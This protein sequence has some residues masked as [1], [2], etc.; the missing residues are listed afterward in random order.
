[1]GKE[2]D[3]L[4]MLREAKSSGA[5]RPSLS[6]HGLLYPGGAI[7]EVTVTGIIPGLNDEW[8]STWQPGT[9]QILAQRGIKHAN[10]L[11][12]TQGRDAALEYIN[13]LPDD[14]ANYIYERSLGPNA[15][16]ANDVV[17][18]KDFQWLNN[19][20][21]GATGG[22]PGVVISGINAAKNAAIKNMSN[23]KYHT[24]GQA[25][26]GGLGLDYNNMPWYGKVGVEL[27][28]SPEMWLR[29]STVKSG[30]KS[31][32][33][34]IQVVAQNTK[35]LVGR[36]MTNSDV[37]P[38]YS[39][40]GT[41]SMNIPVVKFKKI[42]K[43]PISKV[44]ATVQPSDGGIA[45]N[46]FSNGTQIGTRVNYP[47]KSDGWFSRNKIE[48]SV[49]R[50]MGEGATSVEY[51]YSYPKEGG[52][53]KEF[54]IGGKKYAKTYDKK[55]DLIKTE[56]IS[57]DTRTALTGDAVPK[58]VFEVPSK[59][60]SNTTTHTVHGDGSFW[61]GLASGVKSQTP[62][63]NGV[64]GNAFGNWLGK[65]GMRSLYG[66][67]AYELGTFVSTLFTEHGLPI[68][69]ELFLKRLGENPKITTINDKINS[70]EENT[71]GW[72]LFHGDGNLLERLKTMKTDSEEKAKEVLNVG[73][74]NPQGANITYSIPS[75]TTN[76]S[77]ITW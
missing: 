10:N 57:G 76:M 47:L 23:G 61:G 62:G 67:G 32:G 15:D 20:M 66:L 49:D 3:K 73:N 34:G 2:K 25:I 33:N 19:F 8:G 42:G 39:T 77:K 70:V 5:Q 43:M 14:Y 29:P 50:P 54:E 53:V 26:S 18:R 58:D 74:S 4:D 52:Y 41:F 35:N 38:T 31:M 13:S 16:F 9:S 68:Q 17:G 27:L 69:Q 59:T 56:E 30:V 37:I 24:A 51:K 22:V 6:E 71:P 65:W 36:L 64:S 63:L 40:S 28:G 11:L 21:F 60:S 7:D 75:D 1:M 45:Y 46:V 55:G 12:Q 44:E 72:S 48:R